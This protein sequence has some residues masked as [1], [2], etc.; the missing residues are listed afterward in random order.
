MIKRRAYGLALSGA[1]FYIPMQIGAVC[2][3]MDGGVT[4]TQVAGTSAGS[5][6]AAAIAIGM[7]RQQLEKVAVD[8]DFRPLF[9]PSAKAIISR[10]GYCN[11]DRLHDF[12]YEVLGDGAMDETIIPL[13][14]MASDLR[15]SRGFEFSAKAHP[16][17]KVADA[18]RA[19]M[20]VPIAF[21]PYDYLGNTLADGG[22]RCNMPLNK[23]D[24]VGPLLGIEMNIAGENQL[25]GP[26]D[27]AFACIS[28]MLAANELDSLIW[29]KAHGAKIVTLDPIAGINFMDNDLAQAERQAM[30]NKGYTTM[31]I[32]MHG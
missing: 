13:T 26:I 12:L 10:R 1:G 20:S 23:L 4:F 18:C 21:V 11:G 29:G 32:A 2:A 3:L 27:L 7:T 5:A 25:D 31:R 17:A 30:F 6:V 24:P 9:G 14:I 16:S 19:S 15:R 22:M 8:T 28:M